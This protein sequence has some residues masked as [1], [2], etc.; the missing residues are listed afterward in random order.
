MRLRTPSIIYTLDEGLDLARVLSHRF[1]IDIH[2]IREYQ[3]ERRSLDVRHKQPKFQSIF[4]IDVP[5]EASLISHLKQQGCTEPLLAVTFPAFRRFEVAPR[6]AIVGAG[7]SGLFAAMAFAEAGIGADIFERGKSVP[8]RT[9]DVSRLMNQG[10]LDIESNICFGEGGAGTFSDGKLM[11]RTK[12]KYIP[13]I[14]EKFVQFGADRRI[15]YESHPHIGTDR[16]SPLLVEMR[17]WLESHSIRYHFESRVEDIL[18]ENGRCK[19]I[20][21]NGEQ[22]YYDAV[23][24]CVGHSA[25]DIFECLYGHGVKLEPKPLAIGVR[26]EHPQALINQIQ[27]GTYAGHSLLPPAEYAVRFNDARL[28]SAFSFC[29]CPGGKIVPSQTSHDACVVNGM[30]GSFR[31]GKHA[32]AALV[33][34]VGEESFEEGALGG[35]RWIRKLERRAAEYCPASYAPAES[36]TDFLARR[37]HVKNPKTTYSPGTIG[38]NLHEILP[39]RVSKALMAALPAFD[40]QMRGFVT[41]EANLVGIESRTSSPVRIVRD[42]CYEATDISGLYPVGEGAGY[43]GG[44]TSCALDGIHAALAFIEQ[45]RG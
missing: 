28:G 38:A 44:I 24:L 21:V 32:N 27:Y 30:S 40:R 26:I 36:V 18:I 15:L 35:L 41:Q 20:V 17:A 14:L 19:G 3:F 6:V 23:F 9:S 37:R 4:L 1:G 11:T 33:V 31:N 7:P 12:S 16:L 10:Q 45:Y 43:A 25:D 29:M 34:P 22:C 2:L 5:D 42:P 13:L 8:L 39:E